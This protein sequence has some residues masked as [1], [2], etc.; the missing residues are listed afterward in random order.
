MNA[1]QK[2]AIKRA[3]RMLFCTAVLLLAFGAMLT[4]TVPM[5]T[6]AWAEGEEAPLADAVAEPAAEAAETEEPPAE[7]ESPVVETEEPPAEGDS[8]AAEA[9]EPSADPAAAP[10][11]V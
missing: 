8:P 6:L 10:A 9:E 11:P 4:F 2:T 3:M 1:G 5:R 7:A